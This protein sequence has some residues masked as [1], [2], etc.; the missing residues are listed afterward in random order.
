M[1]LIILGLAI[2][3]TGCA[4]HDGQ[5]VINDPDCKFVGKPNDYRLPDKCGF[6]SYGASTISVIKISPSTYVVNK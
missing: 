6:K 5:R 3:L 2:A 1:K 4:Y